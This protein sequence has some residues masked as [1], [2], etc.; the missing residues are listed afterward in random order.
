MYRD[1]LGLQLAFTAGTV[2]AY[3][4][5]LQ[6]VASTAFGAMNETLVSGPRC[7]MAD[8]RRNSSLVLPLF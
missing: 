8:R 3:D 5:I 7:R 6:P 1:R 4:G 2:V